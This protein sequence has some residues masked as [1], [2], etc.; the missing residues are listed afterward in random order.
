MSQQAIESLAHFAG[1]PSELQMLRDR[2][3]ELE[4]VLGIT[5]KELALQKLPLSP[6][7][8]AILGMLYRAKSVGREQIYTGIWGAR[9][10][11]DQPSLNIVDVQLCRVK[12]LLKPRGITVHGRYGRGWW[13]DDEDKAKIREWIGGE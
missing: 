3:Q 6:Q 11:C 5:T 8:C 1:K 12:A 10:E 2:V 13:I 7:C 9:P 4:E